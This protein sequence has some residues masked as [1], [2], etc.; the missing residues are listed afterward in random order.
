MDM[1]PA[2]KFEQ[3]QANR[4]TDFSASYTYIF[5]KNLETS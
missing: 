5:H 2:S 4:I 1:F 3:K